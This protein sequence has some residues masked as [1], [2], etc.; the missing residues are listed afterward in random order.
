M[1]THDTM[2]TMTQHL[3]QGLCLISLWYKMGLATLVDLNDFWEL[4][5]PCCSLAVVARLS[6]PLSPA[7]LMC[8]GACTRARSAGSSL[9]T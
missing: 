6:N 4:R 3:A 5:S 1:S 7:Q 9:S 8:V 2:G